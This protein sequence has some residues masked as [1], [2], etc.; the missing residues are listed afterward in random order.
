MGVSIM[1]P[2]QTETLQSRL[3]AANARAESAV[4]AMYAAIAEL[5]FAAALQDDI[6]GELYAEVEA[7]E[8]DVS[9]T[10]QLAQD[11]LRES[12]NNASTA[13][14]AREFVNTI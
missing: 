4:T 6:A 12:I 9:S 14:R 8:R 13:Q 11:V 2:V 1:E 3:A 10:S 7:L 5:E